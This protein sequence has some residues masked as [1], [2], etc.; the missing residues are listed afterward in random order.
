MINILNRSYDIKLDLQFSYNNNPDLKFMQ[1]DK[2]TSDF[3]I[4]IERGTED[5]NLSNTIITLAVIKPDNTTDAMFL[6]IRNDKLYADLK[7]SM[8]DLVGTYQARAMLVSGDETV[9]TDV[10]TYT[11]NEDKILSQL[12]SDI[13]SDER[14]SILTDMLN[15]LS[16]IET[17]ETNRVEAEKLREEKIKELIDEANK[18]IQNINSTIE[19]EVNKIVPKIVNDTTNEYLGTVKEDLK[20]AVNDANK[21]IEEV[22]N[23]I[24]EV[25][26]FIDEKNN[27][28]NNFIEEANVNIDKA[29]KD[30]PPGPPGPPGPKGETGEQGEPGEQGPP[31]E[32]GKDG[33]NGED[34]TFNPDTEFH[35]LETTNKTVLGAINELFNEIKKI[36]DADYATKIKEVRDIQPLN[37]WEV[38]SNQ[39]CKLTK[40]DLG[41]TI[42]EFQIKAAQ[43]IPTNTVSFLLPEG[44]GPSKIMPIS[45]LVGNSS[46][47]G[48]IYKDRQVKFSGTYTKGTVITYTCLI[49]H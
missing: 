24:S 26:N 2:N 6:D 20:N 35:E 17:N 5:V 49:V 1:F 14:Y 40:F 28:V 36:N 34:G 39:I 30:I 46:K 43:E 15:N 8:K 22:D 33:K 41:F 16:E 13:V 3:F 18:A 31:G 9:T 19:N 42:F 21:K 45:F 7:P 32:N 44:F 12:N 4:R 29:I 38:T 25:N 10:I 23:K 47:T 48:F 37:G 27:Q 11:V